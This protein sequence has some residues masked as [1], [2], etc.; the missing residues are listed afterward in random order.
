MDRIIIFGT[1]KHLQ[2]R[3]DYLSSDTEILAFS[4]NNPGLWEHD[5]LG[6]K[7]IAHDEI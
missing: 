1:G 5:Y 3:I 7:I 6:K 2:N 4:D